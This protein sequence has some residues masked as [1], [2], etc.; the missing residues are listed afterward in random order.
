MFS[1]VQDNRLDYLPDG[2]FSLPALQHLDVSNNKLSCLPYSMWGAPKLREL[3][4]SLNLLSNLPLSPSQH[5]LPEPLEED[6]SPSATESSPSLGAKVVPHGEGEEETGKGKGPLEGGG[7]RGT[8]LSLDKHG[9]VITCCRQKE[10]KHHSLW[11]QAVQVRA[12]RSQMRRWAMVGRVI[13]III[14]DYP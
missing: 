9:N 1:L 13:S 4:L 5:P 3:N 8:A 11:T 14:L 2:L 12:S 10:V 7:S 6:C